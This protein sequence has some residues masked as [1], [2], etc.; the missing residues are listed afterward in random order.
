MLKPPAGG[1]GWI[2]PVSVT[3][4]PY[5]G[6]ALVPIYCVVGDTANDVNDVVMFAALVVWVN[7]MRETNSKNVMK[8]TLLIDFNRIVLQKDVSDFCFLLNS[9]L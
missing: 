5:C 4:V 8:M 6:S 1:L 9:E 2:R 7:T 3:V